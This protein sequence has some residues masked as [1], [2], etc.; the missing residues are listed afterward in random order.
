VDSVQPPPDL[1]PGIIYSYGGN[2]EDSYRPRALR[3]AHAIATKYEKFKKYLK[4]RM[5]ELM[6]TTCYALRWMVL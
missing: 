3:I 2:I 4:T 5:Q 1:K 6:N